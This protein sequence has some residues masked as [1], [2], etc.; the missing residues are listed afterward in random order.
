MKNKGILDILLLPE[1]FYKN[2]TDSKTSLYIGIFAVGIID[3]IFAVSDKYQKIFFNRTQP[4]LLKNIFISL[5]FVIVIGLADIL[6]F[7]YPIFDLLKK[8]KK[9][10]EDKHNKNSVIKLMKIQITANIVGFIPNILL[11][12]L[13][14]KTDVE[15]NVDLA[16][17][18]FLVFIL[19][20]VWFCAIISKGI[21]SIYNFEQ[22]FR[23]LVLPVVFLWTFATSIAINFIIDKVLMYILK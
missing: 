7:S 13:S 17:A 3:L 20:Q 16:S 14:M 21:K 15:N 5:M 6:F 12:I 4:D 11:T 18:L 22:K 1:K 8:F 2:F 23:T 9:T 10:E 19:L